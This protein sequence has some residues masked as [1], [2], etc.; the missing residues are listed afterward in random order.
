MISLI[1]SFYDLKRPNSG[2]KEQNC[3]T[4]SWVW[5]NWGNAGQMMQTFSQKL[6]KSGYLTHSIVIIVDNNVLYNSKFQRRLVIK[7]SHHKI[8]L[9]IKL[10]PVI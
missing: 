9:I 3:G 7:Y 4:K 2:N 10:Q 5:E 1:W 8:E 6:V